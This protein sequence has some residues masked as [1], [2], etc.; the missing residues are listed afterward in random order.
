MNLHGRLA[1]LE[2]AGNGPAARL[3]VIERLEH[4]SNSEATAGIHPTEADTVIYLT[5][6]SVGAFSDDRQRQ[7]TAQELRA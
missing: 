2:V 3:F 1:R 4:E 7:V 5:R 6:F